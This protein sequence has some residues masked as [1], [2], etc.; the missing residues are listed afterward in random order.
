[1]QNPSSLVLGASMNPPI[2]ILECFWLSY[3]S[4]PAWQNSV[5]ER[6]H[7]PDQCLRLAW[8]LHLERHSNFRLQKSND[9]LLVSNRP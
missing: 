5:N 9:L 8:R 2:P 1:M 4:G 3:L 6:H 7:S